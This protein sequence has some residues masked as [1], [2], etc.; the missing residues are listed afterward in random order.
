[1]VTIHH[2]EVHLDVAGDDDEVAFRRLFEKYMRQWRRLEAEAEERR[3][4]GEEER[5]LP[6]GSGRGER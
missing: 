1:M 6:G 5:R 3:R 2:L 4:S